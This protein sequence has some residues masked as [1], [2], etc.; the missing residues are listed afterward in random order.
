[1]KGVEVILVIHVAYFK[2]IS[3]LLLLSRSTDRTHFVP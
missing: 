3:T 2:A 1:M